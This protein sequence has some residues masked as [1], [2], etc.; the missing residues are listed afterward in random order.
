MLHS[1]IVL[2]TLLS[3]ANGECN[4]ELFQDK[5]YKGKSLCF[6]K[7]HPNFDTIPGDFNDIFSSIKVVSSFLQKY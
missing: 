5:D 1:L 7:D 2:L 3:R 4:C 6:D